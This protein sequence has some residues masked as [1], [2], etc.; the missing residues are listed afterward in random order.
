MKLQDQ[1]Y[2]QYV[3]RHYI[4]ICKKT[5]WNN[6]RI[7]VVLITADQTVQTRHSVLKRPTKKF[8]FSCL[9]YTA[10]EIEN[11][12]HYE[13]LPQARRTVLCVYGAVRGVGGIDSWG[14]DVEDD[15]RIS[16]EEDIDYSFTIC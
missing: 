2:T 1:R 9:P 14:S 7:S 3:Q 8:A 15:Y 16:A 5:I 12:L 4:S 6:S 10:S 11:A 13:E